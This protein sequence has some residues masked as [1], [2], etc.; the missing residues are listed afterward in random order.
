MLLLSACF[1]SATQ[2][3]FLSEEAE[4]E[5]LSFP[6]SLL[7]TNQSVL[8]TH[9]PISCCEVEEDAAALLQSHGNSRGFLETRGALLKNG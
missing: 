1:S 9:L 6:D 2:K 7:S 8:R 4:E 5:E 3:K